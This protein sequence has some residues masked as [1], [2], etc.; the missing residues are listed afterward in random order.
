MKR[1]FPGALQ[2]IEAELSGGT[3]GVAAIFLPTGES[4]SFKADEI[5]PTASVIKVAIVAELFIRQAEGSISPDATATV[6][7]EA[8]VAGSGVLAFLKPGLTLPLT[9]LAML[10]I[11]VSDNTASNLC[12]AAVGGPEAVNH[13]MRAAWGLTETTI[14]RPI[15]F[16]LE[17]DDPLYTAI[18]TPRDML[19]LLTLLESGKVHDRTVSNAVLRCMAEVHDAEL[20]PRYLDVNP[21]ADDLRVDR[22]PFQVRHKTG[23]VSGVRNDAALIT[24]GADTL[25]VC[26]YTR[27]VPDARWT[28]ENAASRAVAAVGRLLRDGFFPND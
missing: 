2:A 19:R 13:R 5:F 24:S 12:L 14:H 27:G 17:P 18:G 23:A 4:V 15:K 16:A 6:T 25:A 26:V 28:P 22:S 9:D 20:L 1:D 10:A 21:Y 7:A 11:C 8:I 3:L